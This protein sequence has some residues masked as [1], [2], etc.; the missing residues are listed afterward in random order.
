MKFEDLR[1]YAERDWARVERSKLAHWVRQYQANAS[2]PSLRA[3]DALRSHILRHAHSASFTE[4][5][6]DLE[7]LVR[8]KHRI[9]AANARLSR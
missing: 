2:G 9:D 8:L 1:A 7:D 4:R 6:R 5:A 3:A